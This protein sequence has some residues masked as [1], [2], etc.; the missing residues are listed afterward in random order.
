MQYISLGYFCSIA[1]ELEKMGLRSESSPFDWLISD[2]DGVISAIETR[3]EDFL[4]PA[5]LAQNKN[6]RSHYKNTK[7]NIEFFHDF[8]PYASLQDQ[9]QNVQEKYNRRIQRFYQSITEPTLFIRYISDVPKSCSGVNEV[10]W[11]EK[12]YASIIALLKSFNEQND[13]LF[14]ANDGVT[15][16]KIKIYNVP[17]DDGDVVARKPFSKNCSLEEFFNNVDLPERERNIER[18]LAKQQL[19]RRSKIKRK[20]SSSFKKFFKKEYIHN[21]LY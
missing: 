13:I 19:K 11:I 12:N 4:N 6:N 17:K 18:Y 2:F 3:F 7:Y 21:Q 16:Q 14:I 20:I 9:L 15:S 8:N 1:M 5:F 10:L